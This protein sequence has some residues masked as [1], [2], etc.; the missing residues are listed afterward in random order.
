MCIQW[1][2]V[3]YSAVITRQSNPP[4][5]QF[6]SLCNEFMSVRSMFVC[7]V[8][9][10]YVYNML[11]KRWN[12]RSS[13]R[14]WI[15]LRSS[16]RVWIKLFRSSSR[17]GSSYARLAVFGSSYARLAVFGSSYARLAVFGSSYARLA[18]F[19]SSY[20]DRVTKLSIQ[21]RALL[22]I[23]SFYYFNVYALSSK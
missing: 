13:S 4:I 15:K 21:W 2:R 10:C 16:S 23:Q 6:N 18:V 14:V 1:T 3:L 7:Y 22:K 8:M 11:V 12:Y 17:V 19:G 20:F 5:Q 9:L